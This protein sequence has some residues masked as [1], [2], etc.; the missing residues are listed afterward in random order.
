MAIGVIYNTLTYGGVNSG[1]YG[2]YITGEAVFNAPERDV[3][4][5]TIPGRSGQLTIDNGR[6]ENIEVE[7]PAGMFGADI[8]EFREKLSDFRNAVM[9]LKGYQKLTDTYHPD[10]FRMAM[11]IEGFEVAPTGYNRAGEFTLK[12]NCKPQRYLTSG[13]EFINY[14]QA[15]TNPTPFDSSPLLAVKG[16]GDIGMVG[17]VSGNQYEINIPNTRIGEIELDRR[18]VENTENRAVFEY[19]CSKMNDSDMITVN[20]DIR[21]LCKGTTYQLDMI[22][23][24]LILRGSSSGITSAIGMAQG[25]VYAFYISFENMQFQKTDTIRF[26]ARF[27][28]VINAEIKI[29]IYVSGDDMD[30]V[31]TPANSSYIKLTDPMVSNLRFIANSTKSALGNPSYIDCETGECWK[32]EDGVIY[33]LNNIIKFT[34]LPKLEAGNT[35]IIPE[36]TITELKIKPR[37]WKI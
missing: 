16:Y 22:A 13:D 11:F 20:G 1:D 30:L 34:D 19:S 6:F 10:E 7:Y 3:E 32:E 21:I 9:S 14:T 23:E 35:V 15:T 26:Y 12:F 18:T 24:N 5:I 2:I 25:A 33:S 37:W 17:D 27:E 8:S 28:S 31:I 4:L 29:E 36:R